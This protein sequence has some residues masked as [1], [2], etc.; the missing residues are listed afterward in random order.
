MGFGS[1]IAS[2]KRRIAPFS[3][4][5][6]TGSASLPMSDLSSMDLLS[7]RGELQDGDEAVHPPDRR[8]GVHDGPGRGALARNPA[9]DGQLQR[10][11]TGDL[12][13]VVRVLGPCVD[14]ELQRDAL[15]SVD[16]AA[17]RLLDPG[18]RSRAD[19][20]LSGDVL[21]GD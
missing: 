18:D 11:G 17:H 13:V 1:P 14:P 7:S 15:H 12:D 20:P 9:V 10:N 5:T 8:R 2:A 16:V 3:T 19:E 4:S 6:T 21:L